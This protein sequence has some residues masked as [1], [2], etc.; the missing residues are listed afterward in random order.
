MAEITF[1]VCAL[2]LSNPVLIQTYGGT[3]RYMGGYV[4]TS[5]G[6]SS[7]RG[8]ESIVHQSHFTPGRHQSPSD[9]LSP[10]CCHASRVNSNPEQP[11]VKA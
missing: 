6:P 10:A 4:C 3:P 5:H 2:T 8:K 11:R 9:R 1:G 7:G